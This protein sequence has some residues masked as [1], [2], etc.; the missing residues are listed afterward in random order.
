MVHAVVFV[1]AGRGVRPRALR[2]GQGAAALSAGASSTASNV[3]LDPVTGQT[4]PNVFVGSFV[5]GTGD[6]YNGMVTNSDPNYPKGLPRQSGHRAGAAPWARLGSGR[7]RQDR[8][9]RERGPV[10]QP[11]RQRERH[12]RDG[13]ESPGA[14][15]A[16]HL[17][18]HAWT[19][20]SQPGAAGA[21]SN[22]PSAVFGV[23]RDAKTPKSYNYSVG[24]QREIGWGTVIDVTYAGFQMRHGEMIDEHQRRS[25]RGALPRRPSGERE[26]AD[27]DV[28]RSRTIPAA[29]F[30][31]PGHHHSLALRHVELQL[32][33]GAAEPALH[34]RPAVRRGLHVR[35]RPRAWAERRSANLRFR[36]GPGMRGT[37]RR[38]RR[39]SSTTWSSTTRGTCPAAAGCGTTGS[40]AARST[41]GSYRATPR[42]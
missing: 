25:G 41:A 37:S 42:S 15:H 26:S 13:E 28:Q 40:R 30:R 1:A 16:E 8:H 4:L 35:P 20:C 11:P 5:P 32:A 12:G 24:V 23:E 7:R 6:R 22:R 27:G 21:F 38:R 18:R 9:P 19:R 2:S 10:S 34:Q 33:A 39:R 36:T 14:E 3:A 31:L 29:V 17:L